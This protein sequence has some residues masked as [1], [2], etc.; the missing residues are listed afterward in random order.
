MKGGFRLAQTKQLGR[1]NRLLGALRP[2]RLI[3]LAGRNGKGDVVSA[4]GIL[5]CRSAASDFNVIWMRSDEQYISN[6]QLFARSHSR[7][8]STR[9]GIGL[10]VS[11][12]VNFHA[13]T[14]T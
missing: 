1:F 11:S 14:T 6:N 9:S 4:I 13:D 3:C 12:T 10:K 7:F 2:L 5:S 8:Q